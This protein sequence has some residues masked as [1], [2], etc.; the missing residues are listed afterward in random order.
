MCWLAQ[1]L[2]HRH[3]GRPPGII[4]SSSLVSSLCLRWCFRWS[5]VRCCPPSSSSGF[6]TPCVLSL[7]GHFVT[8]ACCDYNLSTHLVSYIPTHHQCSCPLGLITDFCRYS[9]LL[10]S[11]SISSPLSFDPFRK[12]TRGHSITSVHFCLT[13]AVRRTKLDPTSG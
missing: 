7:N 8:W 9:F 12:K 10:F 11:T 5:L 4:L 1:V 3:P 6:L 2:R 13:A